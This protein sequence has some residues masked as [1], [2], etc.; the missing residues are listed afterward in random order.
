[1]SLPLDSPRRKIPSRAFL[2]KEIRMSIFSIVSESAVF[3]FFYINAGISHA[4]RISEGTTNAGKLYVACVFDR[5]YG[6]GE[7]CVTVYNDADD[8]PA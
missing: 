3:S 8:T 4:K 7:V 1:M 5:R 2:H 6:E